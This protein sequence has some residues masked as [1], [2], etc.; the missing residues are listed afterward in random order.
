MR[1]PASTQPVPPAQGK[2]APADGQPPGDP[3]SPRRR[4]GRRVTKQRIFV[5]GAAGLVGQ[6]LI[7]RLAADPNLEIVAVDKHRANTKILEQLHPRITVLEEDL[8]APG[9]WEH[10]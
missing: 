7:A 10:H 9:E 1:L 5:A 2:P 4:Q 6:N 3:I 8:A